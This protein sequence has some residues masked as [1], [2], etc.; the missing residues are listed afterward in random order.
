MGRICIAKSTITWRI[1]N[2]TTHILFASIACNYL[3]SPCPVISSV[4]FGP[5]RPS[6][7]L[8]IRVWSVSFLFF[9]VM[10]IKSHHSQVL[11][12][13]ESLSIVVTEYRLKINTIYGKVNPKRCP[14]TAH[15]VHLADKSI[16][17]KNYNSHSITNYIYYQIPDLL[18]IS[19][20]FK[21]DAR[22]FLFI[23]IAILF[24]L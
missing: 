13:L 22:H 3:F 2:R 1:F 21:V 8:Y 6:S 18:R 15:N 10:A 7:P 14:K 9:I 11:S 24:K 17:K 16:D 23:L 5:L 19:P 12:R 4:L 20:H